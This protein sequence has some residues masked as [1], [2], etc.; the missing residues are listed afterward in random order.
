[1]IRKVK[2]RVERKLVALIS[3]AIVVAIVGIVQ[4]N[5]NLPGLLEWLTSQARELAAGN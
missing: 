3:T 2:R 4:E 5:I 1:M